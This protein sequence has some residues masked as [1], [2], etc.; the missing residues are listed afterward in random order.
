MTSLAQ[1]AEVLKLARVLDLPP[2]RLEFLEKLDPLAIRALRER[3][4]AALFGAEQTAFQR[5][6]AA[7]RQIPA[8]LS[9]V[10]AERAF[11]S[12]LCAR[13]TGLLAPDRAV[14]VAR[15][16]RTG[17]LAD[18]CLQLDPRTSHHVLQAMPADR[19]AE[20]AAELAS[21]GEYITMGR[22]VDNI[23][24][25]AIHATAEALE[26]E[27]LLR[28]GLFV[29]NDTRLSA[30]MQDLP[31]ERLQGIVRAAV[32]GDE[33]LWQ[34]A[35]ALIQRLDEAL[36]RRM[37]DLAAE[38]EEDAIQRMIDATHE[39]DLWLDML[40]II[41]IMNPEN[42][43]RLVELSLLQEEHVVGTVL[44][45]AE[46]HD[47]WHQLLPMLAHIEDESRERLAGIASTHAPGAVERIRSGK[48]P[49]G[50]GYPAKGRRRQ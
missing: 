43:R 33:E 15:R 35:V 37:A 32:G 13:L 27:A 30:I 10:L 47:L 20:V 5:I 1:H 19:I 41:A 38:M 23:S 49:D 39:Q 26:D 7:S 46:V 4:S 31:R 9:A 18:V 12:L 44:R 8:G 40:G 14:D 25:K 11:G 50:S 6:A 3:A 21:R 36:R 2:E 24:D 22:F 29:E 45:T 16:L 48:A 17:F 42:Q 34:E 28:I